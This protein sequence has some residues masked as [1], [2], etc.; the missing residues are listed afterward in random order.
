MINAEKYTPTDSG[1]I[2]TG[3]LANVTGTPFD[4]TKETPIGARI[5]QK[6][7]QLKFGRGYD[8]NWVLRR[9]GNRIELAAR[10][11]EPTSGR[12]MEVRTTEPGL[13][14]YSGELSRWFRSRKRRK[15]ISISV[16]LL[17]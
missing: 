8:H 15:S 12:V 13:Q 16:G 14:F 11:F 10:V 2:P 1:S 3:T 9:N 17:P 6:N 7:E 4:F 5:D